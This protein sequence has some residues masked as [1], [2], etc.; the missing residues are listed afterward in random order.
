MSGPGGAL[1]FTEWRS[2]SLAVKPTRHWFSPDTW[3]IHHWV[4]FRNK[5]H[6]LLCFNLTECVC[7][8]VTKPTRIWWKVVGPNSGNVSEARNNQSI[9]VFDRHINYFD[10]TEWTM[11]R[12]FMFKFTFK[13]VHFLDSSS[14]FL[15]A[16]VFSLY[17]WLFIIK[18][19]V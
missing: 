16:F 9:R 4:R 18:F 11:Q 5:L 13:I 1:C 12:R 15:V 17:L 14:R 10:F 6:K 19:M 3:P 7:A 8:N 2:R